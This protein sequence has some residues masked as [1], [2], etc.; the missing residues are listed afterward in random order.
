[1]TTSVETDI[2]DIR[3]STS[4]FVEQ[5]IEL[6]GYEDTTFFL[7]IVATAMMGNNTSKLFGASGFCNW[8][9]EKDWFKEYYGFEHFDYIMLVARKGYSAFRA[10]LRTLK[11]YIKQMDE[12]RAKQFTA[13]VD[14]VII[15]NT[16]TSLFYS[17]NHDGQG[18][19][20]QKILIFDDLLSKGRNITR[21]AINLFRMGFNPANIYYS[22]LGYHQMHKESY[23]YGH[24]STQCVSI[25][26]DG[27]G[28]Y[29]VVIHNE[30][31]E[32]I[33]SNGKWDY[34]KIPLFLPH[35]FA[36]KQLFSSGLFMSKAQTNDLSHNLNKFIHYC[37]VPYTGYSSYGYFNYNDT[38]E[39]EE[40]NAFKK[41]YVGSKNETPLIQKLNAHEL[42]IEACNGILKDCHFIIRGHNSKNG[43]FS[44]VKIFKNDEIKEIMINPCI[45]LPSFTESQTRKLYTVLFSGVLEQPELIL[46]NP[47][48][49]SVYKYAQ[50]NTQENYNNIPIT[51]NHAEHPLELHGKLKRKHVYE[52]MSRAVFLVLYESH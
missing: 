3:N 29:A 50:N 47:M 10:F 32:F 49:S 38:A 37:V 8:G 13:L 52:H 4:K 23:S 12:E 7:E 19:S 34:S 45:I 46:N 16:R 2:T 51:F 44:G 31:K 15:V 40:H 48:M 27:N 42:N 21:F 18:V 25:N 35:R 17:F 20:N 24:D 5:A 41:L 28:R 1:M 14:K 39:T 22:A 26:H 6:F 11:D 36:N 9:D 30:T 33:N 43:Y